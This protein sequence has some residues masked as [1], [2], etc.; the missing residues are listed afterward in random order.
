M[1]IGV[2]LS[3]MDGTI[4]VSSYAAIGSELEELQN[5]SWIATSYLLTLASCQSVQLAPLTIFISSE[6]YIQTVIRKAERYLWAKSM[7]SFRIHHICYWLS[8]LR[9]GAEHVSID[10]SSRVCWHWWRWDDHVSSP[11]SGEV[12][13]LT[14]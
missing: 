7:S 6:F 10:R 5:T 14:F 1:A 2:L 3:A 13:R 4:V 9:P 12:Y 8:P 11:C